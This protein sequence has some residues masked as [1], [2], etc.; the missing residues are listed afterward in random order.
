[1]TKTLEL[2]FDMANGKTMT[3][4]IQNPKDKLTS[5]EVVQAM[6]TIINQNIFHHNSFGLVGI[7]QARIVER[8]VTDIQLV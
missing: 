2:K 8:N 3:L 6:Q 7:N 5:A 4:S 1:M